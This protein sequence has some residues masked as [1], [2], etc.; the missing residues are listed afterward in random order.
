MDLTTLI[1]LSTEA[2]RE[3]VV[4]FELTVAH[5]YPSL[6][7]VY[8]S[9]QMIML[10]EMACADAIAPLLPAGWVSVGTHVDVKHLAATPVGMTVTATARVIE[11]SARS[12]RFAVSAHDG[13]DLI[14]EGF[15]ERAP[16]ALSRFEE[17]VA[18]KTAKLGGQP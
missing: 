11:V 5:A 18:R 15:H 4:S 12:V 2:R 17:G 9:P 3:V 16:V 14:G 8:A 13:M 6:P 1:P 7:A 10:M